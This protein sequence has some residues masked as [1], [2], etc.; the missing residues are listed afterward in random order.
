MLNV[1]RNAKANKFSF[2]IS[3]SVS[4]HISAAS[5]LATCRTHICVWTTTRCQG[6]SSADVQ[7]CAGCAHVSGMMSCSCS[8]SW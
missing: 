7:C 3:E 2:L 8:L 1:N 4:L 6:K 5:E